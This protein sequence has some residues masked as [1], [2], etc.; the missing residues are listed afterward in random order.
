[1]APSGR[2]S[3]VSPSGGTG[4]AAN[5]D[6][7]DLFVFED[8]AGAICDDVLLTG[9]WTASGTIITGVSTTF[10]LDTAGSGQVAGRQGLDALDP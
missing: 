3:A 4:L 6:A 9:G 1:M 10:A 8:N 5:G 2:P 7:I